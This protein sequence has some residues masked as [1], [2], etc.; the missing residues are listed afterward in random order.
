[1]DTRPFLYISLPGGGEVLEKSWREELHPRDKHG[2]F[3][4]VKGGSKVI[5]KQGKTG[6]VDK[7]T[8]THYH[9]TTEDGKKSKVLK[10]N[11][12]HV[13]DHSKAMEAK[14]KE[15]RAKKRKAKQAGKKQSAT[16]AV[17]KADGRGKAKPIQDPTEAKKP[18]KK[19]ATKTATKATTATK[20]AEPKKATATKPK[21]QSRAKEALEAPVLKRAKNQASEPKEVKGTIPGAGKA[22][23]KKRTQ[24]NKTSNEPIQDLKNAEATLPKEANVTIDSMWNSPEVQKIMK[25]SPE[26]RNPEKIRE[27][28]GKITNDN[29]LLAKKLA[30]K[31]ASAMGIHM[32]KNQIG[33]KASKT[34]ITEGQETGLYGDMLQSARGAMYETLLATMSGSQNPG[35]GASIGAHVVNRMKDKI[36]NDLYGMLNSIPAPHETRPAIRDMKKHEQELSQVLG[37]TPEHDELAQHMQQNS[38]HFRSAPIAPAPKWDAKKNEWVAGRGKVEDPSERLALLK[39]YDAIQRTASADTNVGSEGEK[40]VT[41]G[42]NAVDE[43]RSP[44]EMYERKERQK[45]LEGALPKA[46]RAMGMSDASIKVWTLT[47]SAPSEKRNVGQLT[48]AEVADHINAE[49]GWEGS[50]ITESWV[51][52]HYSAG[53]KVIEGALASNHPAIAQLALLKSFVFNNM[54]RNVYEFNLIKSLYS[55]GLDETVLTDKFVRTASGRNLFDIKKS[56]APTEYIGSYVTVDSGDVHARIVT[57]DYPRGEELVKAMSGFEDLQKALFSHK[58]GGN[59]AVNQKAGEYIRKNAGKYK[60]MSNDQHARAKAK[61][62][63]LTW[64]EQLLIDNPGSA[65]ISWGGKRILV[66]GGTGEVLYDSKNDAHREEHNSGAQEDKLEFHHEADEAD[67]KKQELMKQAQEAHAKGDYGRSQA[68]WA[69]KHGVK[70][71]KVKNEETGKDEHHLDLDEEGN[72][73]FDHSKHNLVTDHGAQA[74][75][76]SLGDLKDH[77]AKHK[78]SAIDEHHHKAIGMYG[79]LSDEEKDAYDKMSPEEKAHFVGQH[80]GAH[81][82]VKELMERAKQLAS[83]G[84]KGADIHKELE[85][86]LKELAKQT[87]SMGLANKKKMV[88]V[89]NN[90]G[91]HKDMDETLAHVGAQEISRAREEANKRIVPEGYYEIGNK[92]T[93]R[94]M[95]AKLGH[96]IDPDTGNFTTYVQ[97][98][99]DPRTGKH[100][101]TEDVDNSWGQLGK[102]LG[103]KHNSAEKFIYESNDSSKGDAVMQAM[104]E[105]EANE[106]RNQTSLGMQDSMLHKDFQM[107]SQNRDKA[108]NVVSTTYAQDMPDGTQNVVEVDSDGKVTD[109]IMAR[110]IQS[111]SPIKSAEDLNNRLKDAVGTRI[112]VTA[113]MGSDVHI[114]DALGHHVQLVYDGKGAPR[115]IGGAYDGYRFMDS[116]DI[117]KGAIDPHS[118][119]PIK[120]L[121]KNGKLVDRKLSVMNDVPIDKGNAVMYQ[122]GNSWKKGKVRDVQDGNYQVV[123]SKGNLIGMFKKNELR[124]AKAKGRTLSASGQAVVKLA[125]DGTHRMKPSEVFGSDKQGQKAKALFEEALRKAKVKGAFDRDGNLNK[126]LEL[127]D[128]QHQALNKILG[129][130]KAGKAMMKQFN[131]STMPS[132]E[133]HVPEH[134]R[135]D[136]EAEGVAVGKDGTARISAGKFE[137][138]RDIMGGL[139]VDHKA[140][141]YLKDHFK[142]KDRTPRKV[143]DL[144]KDYQPSMAEGI[145][146]D[147][148]RKQFKPDSFLMNPKQGLYG[149]QL[150]G[151]AHLVER[152]R[153]IAGHGMGTGKTILGVMAGLHHKA[154]QKAL[155]RKAGKTLIV[156]PKGIM[157]DWGKEIGTHTNSKALYI[158]SGFKSDKKHPENGRKMWGQEGTEQ[159]AVDFKSF[160]K[161][162]D[163]HASEDHDFHIVSYDTFMRNRDHFA[164]SGMYDNIAI[165]EVHAFKNQGG[166]RGQ[167][168]AETTDKFK[169]V[170]GLSGTPMENDAREAHSLIDTITGGRHELGTKKEFQDKYMMKDKKGKIVGVKPEKAKELGDIMA[171]VVQFRGGEDVTYNDGSKI[172]FPH[173][174][175]AEGTADNPNPKQDFIGNMVDRSRDH[176]TTEYYGTK[177]SVTDFDTDEQTVDP[178]TDNEYKVR[179]LTPKGIDPNSAM[180][181]MYQTYNELQSKYLPESKLKELK[182]A[183]RT[184][185]DGQGSKGNSNYLTAM[186]KLQKYLNAP[187]AH[188]MFVPGGGN[189]IE[190]DATD[191]QTEAPKNGKKGDPIPHVVDADGNK[192]YYESDGK[193]GYLKNEDG[194]PKLLPP[195]HHNNPKA[196]YLHQRIS[197]YLDNLGA[198]NA[199]RRKAGKPELMPKVVVKSSYT[200]FGTDIVDGVLRD[201]QKDHPEL[202]RW[203]D[204]VGDKFGAGRFTGDADDREDT[205]TGFRGNKKDYANNQGH[206]WATTVSPAGKEGVDFGNAHTMFH[207]DQDWNP[208]KMAQ[209]T[210][211]VR[212]SDS[213]KSHNQVD[214]ANA[215]RVESL[216]MPGTIEDFMFDA[217]D[218]KMASIKQ[219]TDATREAEQSD[220][221][222]ETQGT[223]GRSHRGF[224]RGKNNR[225]GAKPKNNVTTTPKTPNK[226]GTGGSTAIGDKKA[227]AEPLAKSLKLVI[228]L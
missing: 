106:L 30:S 92:A 130:S 200:T 84:K 110:F 37:R 161:N 137:H 57:H 61:K 165:D 40:E 14:K 97:E 152:G 126:E 103:L 75:E 166:K 9:I 64:S 215:V 138:L 143:E 18:A 83:E 23:T 33:T 36:N 154:T 226:R 43:G 100:F 224:T 160:K 79:K 16:K 202:A 178:G 177:H 192:R 208:Q 34:V 121:F 49:G 48:S 225:A 115:V 228:R 169:N 65:W 26:K 2:K 89:F 35:E 101:T 107:V 158:G 108:G 155:G 203:A 74:F 102:E 86:E 172:H 41:L 77:I 111:R 167:S 10:D 201:L 135:K 118:G 156:A 163:A 50:P 15:E 187:L 66:N 133:I 90:V 207:F 198:E 42:Q 188:K 95:V 216:H 139:S 174:A 28:A 58:D 140:Q 88:T 182:N 124:N 22:P 173:L 70:M 132:L 122:D 220:K 1:M 80:L 17:K 38:E 131:R 180:G 150:E 179:T 184:G 204:K 175:G 153:G 136:V 170:W 141:E 73:Q 217:Q 183:V 6:V 176:H 31:K 112:W 221:F 105:D 99:F 81:E 24:V 127:D 7:V 13:T 189:A 53:R 157:S 56:L 62:G 67:S 63:Q 186:Q 210:A 114:G 209:F 147:E 214:R 213:A 104:D 193:G 144:K 68:K 96:R 93:G 5:T 199:E 134:L 47:H 20:K 164:N 12:I 32:A 71:K 120:A 55:F 45:E 51:R 219:V 206:L 129:R 211:R 117:P 149:T 87:G 8:S 146:A 194:S 168:L 159:E 191:A 116:K 85:P 222:G 39:Q 218:K 82:G 109:P 145:H 27:L 196:Q 98:A 113:H 151:V 21:K 78:A 19:T 142:R 195:L 190:S 46:M 212:R 60:G 72:L 94:S 119:E 91:K 227:V 171:N 54:L 11:A 223:V 69:E 76:E 123:D 25:Q 4:T 3:T 128:K 125:Q 181:K 29:D 148:F 197:K 44:E 59:N 52:K 162:A 185:I 205:K